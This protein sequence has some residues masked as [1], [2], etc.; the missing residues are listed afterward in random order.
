MNLYSKY[1]QIIKLFIPNFLL[2]LRRLSLGL[3]NKFTAICPVCNFEG[4]FG[5]SGMPIRVGSLCPRC[6]SLER[7]RLFYMKVFAHARNGKTLHFAPEKCLEG[8]FR[9]V[10]EDYQTADLFSFADLMLDIENID[11]PENT[12]DNVICNHVLEHVSDLKAL[13]EI[14]RILN[15]SGNLIISVPQEL[16]ISETIEYPEFQ[17][18][19]QRE[20]YYRQHDHLR[21]YGSDF[22]DRVQNQG[23]KLIEE[24]RATFEEHIE[25]RLLLSDR[26]YKF[27]VV[28]NELDV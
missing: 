25:N 23:F 10:S 11:A 27:E 22:V 19:I 2:D 28:K 17:T 20:K 13:K 5:S 24:F 6:G 3:R 16:N 4:I 12:Y 9:E 1:R 7:H 8:K 14:R 26:I 18:P 21:L 15:K